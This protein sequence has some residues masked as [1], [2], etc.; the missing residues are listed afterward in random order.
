MHVRLGALASQ[1]AAP[2]HSGRALF[3]TQAALEA[4][5][6][7]AHAQRYA[8]LQARREGRPPPSGGRPPSSGAARGGSGAGAGAH[9]ASRGGGPSALG[10]GEGE[11]ASSG[12]TF[13]ERLAASRKKKEEKNDGGFDDSVVGRRV[14]GTRVTDGATRLGTIVERLLTTAKN[15]FRIRYDDALTEE[16]V[17]PAPATVAAGGC[18]RSCRRLHP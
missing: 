3:V 6:A 7:Y 13:L 11:G 2:F 18:N 16:L 5:R 14:R 17:R 4:D 12:L 15:T 10:E 1:G 8:V 9:R